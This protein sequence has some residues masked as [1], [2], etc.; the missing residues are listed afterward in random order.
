MF[1]EINAATEVGRIVGQ[2]LV[3]TALL[4]GALKC[5]SI[6]RRPT[7]NA[8]CALAL[9]II[10][11]A[12]G[13]AGVVGTLTR[14]LGNSPVMALV[15]A[16]TG[17]LMI[18]ALATAALL[19][20]LGL[21]EFSSRR[22][23]Y[24]QGRAQAI[25]ALVLVSIFVFFASAAF[26]R[27]VQRAH[28]FGTAIGQG[29]PD[30]M[31]SFEDLNFRFRS[32][33]RPW[34]SYDGSRLNKASK[35]SFMRRNPDA[36]IIIIA[37]KIGTQSQF[38]TEQLATVGKANLQSAATSSR[39]LSERP[40]QVNGLNGLLVVTEAQV[41]AYQFYYRHWYCFTNGYAY[42]LVGLS[43]S[44]DQ[45][46]VAGELGEMLTRFE[47][48]D[49]NRVAS[50]S[51]GFATNF[52]SSRYNYAV[53]LTNSSWHSFTDLEKSSP[54]AEFGISQGDSC[55]VIT[56]FSFT[57]EKLSEDALVSAFLA[58]MD[59]P[60]P[61]ENLTHE[62]TIKEE[63][64]KGKQF[65]LTRDVNG[66][67][68]H[69]RFRIL[70]GD[71]LAYMLVAWTQRQI[72]DADFILT[73]ALGRVRFLSPTNSTSVLLG[74]A[75]NEHLEILARSF[76][77]NQAGLYDSKQGD[78]EQALPLYIAAA[79]VND[80]KSIY[81]VNALQAWLHLDRPKEALA[82]LETL[83]ASTL[84]LAEIRANKAMFQSQASLTE[85]A[86]TNYA[87]LFGT[88]YRSD[89]HFTEYVNLLAGQKE[90]D[91]AL[92]A[93]QAYLNVQ[94]STTAK[95]LEAQIFRQKKDLP[96]AIG[97]LKNLHEQAPFNTQIASS[98]AETFI[99][100]G[101]FTESLT[102]AHDLIKDNGDSAYY[103]YLKGRSEM[104]LKWY[105]ESKLSFAEAVRLAPA[106][107]DMRSYLDYVSGFLGEGDNSAVMDPIDPVAWPQVLTNISMEQVPAGYA[108]D[109]GAYYLQRIV[110]IAFAPN[111]EYKT[112]DYMLAQILDT[113]GV[114]AFS[115]VQV[116]FNPLTEQVF[117][118][119]VRVTDAEGK[120]IST[121]NPANYYVLDDRST[122]SA[123]QMKV[124]NIPIPGLERGCRLA[125]T[126]T[127]R[128]QGQPNEFPFYAESFSRNIPVRE[129]DFFLSGDAHGLKCR[130]SPSM[131]PQVFTEGLCWR[132]LNPMVT[133]VEPLQ[134]SP[135]NF[136][137]MLWVSDASAQWPAIVSNYLASI[138]DC[139]EPDPM[140]QNLAKSLAAKE[141]KPE[142]KIALLA[143]Y[144]QTN[145]TYKAIE[146]GRR[147]RIPKK[148]SDIIQNKYGDCKD[149]AVL[150][151]QMLVAVGVP[152]RL[153]LVNLHGP[154]QTNQP[155]LD[156]FD[157]MIVY[158]PGD[159]GA[160][161]LDC[162]SKGADVAETIPAGLAGQ[163]ALILD[164]SEPRFVTIPQYAQNAS[165]ISVDQH[166]NVIDERDLAVEESVTF[167]GV[168]ADYFRD[169]LMQVPE[170]SQRV[171]LQNMTDMGDVDLLDFKI[172]SLDTPGKPLCL[173]FTYSIKK[174][175]RGS[176]DRLAGLL[177][178]GFAAAF[179]KAAPADARLTPFQLNIP[180]SLEF[181]VVVDVPKGF[182]A[183]QPANFE[184]NLDP[185][186]ATGHGNVESTAGKL[187]LKLQ[188]HLLTGKF[189]A[190]DYIAYRQ[191][192]SQILSFIE[193]E[194]VFKA[195]KD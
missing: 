4:A 1:S 84:N 51:G 70:H 37:E 193:R 153:A 67:T 7:T 173:R 56:P 33:N 94:D 180:T 110:A 119:A 190:T 82:F 141:D 93:I 27:G 63:D 47:L 69:Y 167:A 53:V 52:Y 156:Q 192:M 188:G 103:E 123:S 120:T 112:T 115:T 86:I 159:V 100:A 12:F 65:D 15:N 58:T 169:Y 125:I 23:I 133:R 25:W 54:M 150:L 99:L 60:Y 171:A 18:A 79:K 142:L 145:L 77:L 3:L 55:M 32:P 35:I 109:Y 108:K 26:I 154:I 80:Q 10:L 91:T 96:K 41:G 6:S 185:R 105:R 191:T 19:A 34:V 194:I 186:F 89:T 40:W 39:V 76:I 38:T 30:Q 137:P 71:G 116:A 178:G 11:L 107:K 164:H 74:S 21:I 117:V 130:T 46:R 177:Q 45:D 16:V 98:L 172:D 135:A 97:L 59:I 175:F 75:A 8:K 121:G 138:S 48:I 36:S 81:I 13:F 139:L 22:E 122:P 160:Q 134:S 64:L 127:R 28:G 140:L 152:A 49:P 179:I 43:K 165:G 195:D 126:F 132:V 102:I 131:Q 85:Q 174:L 118:N 78:Y 151:Q 29:R 83:P 73:D 128:Q 111:K 181:N 104:G 183:V 113:S 88:G 184:L 157:H 158:I 187:I 20:I 66:L 61:N 101:Q 92:A 161:F 182:K 14:L 24:A 148:P 62:R 168:H 72:Q 44:E 170:A 176:E 9:M 17:L 166:L 106:N 2:I 114:S 144:V 5:W 57:T 68:F 95:L 149:H 129:S 162:T 143:R 42:Q 146:F 50:Y 136:L 189:K 31:L 147:A 124:L 87:G 90:F 163:E 155:S